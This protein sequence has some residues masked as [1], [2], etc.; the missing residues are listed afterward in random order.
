MELSRKRSPFPYLRCGTGPA[1]LLVPGLGATTDFWSAQLPGLS[2]HYTVFAWDQRGSGERQAE[3]PGYRLPE[4]AEEVAV[5]IKSA[6]EGPVL[7]VGHSM[8][9]AVCEHVALAGPSQLRGLVLSSAWARPHPGFSA[10]IAARRKIL[11]QV[12]AEAY[13]LASAA[14]TTPPAYLTAPLF[15]AAAIVAHAR[16]FDIPAELHR[17]DALANHD[18]RDRVGDIQLPVE[19]LAAEDDRLTPVAMTEELAALLPNAH[20]SL[21]P[22]GGHRGPQTNPAQFSA[23][24]LKGL[25]RLTAA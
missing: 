4:L 9:A 24:L 8:G 3:A 10:L 22:D 1:V 17:L 5:L 14:M 25:A 6:V 13:L 7:L 19:L 20:L 16:G 12:G 2:E 11:E 15:D 18:L 21:L 23:A